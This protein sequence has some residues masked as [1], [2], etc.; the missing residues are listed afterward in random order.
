MSAPVVSLVDRVVRIGQ[1]PIVPVRPPLLVHDWSV[2]EVRMLT[3]DRGEVPNVAW[4][5][6]GVDLD[7]LHGCLETRVMRDGL[8]YPLVLTLRYTPGESAETRIGR[9]AVMRYLNAVYSAAYGVP[10]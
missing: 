8:D 10:A 9:E 5:R 7:P 2:R 4:V 1:R 6:T 3:I